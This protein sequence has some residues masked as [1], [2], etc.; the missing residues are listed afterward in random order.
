MISQSEWLVDLF[1]S[2]NLQV[3]KHF[4]HL[5]IFWIV[6]SH[7]GC[8]KHGGWKSPIPIQV[9]YHTST[10]SS[11]KA[12]FLLL[13]CRLTKNDFFV[14]N[15]EV[16]EL[17]PSMCKFGGKSFSWHFCKLLNNMLIQWILLFL[18]TLS[19]REHLLIMVL[20]FCDMHHLDK[21]IKL[22]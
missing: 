5:Y 16:L 19:L 15:K 21:K 6:V 1:P 22:I 8:S 10:P 11:T 7:N 18:P 4:N 17:N 20:L 9:E 2:P 3:S 13:K 14:N 12:A